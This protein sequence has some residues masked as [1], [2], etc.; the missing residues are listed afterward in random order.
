MS[1]M[2]RMEEMQPGADS[3]VVYEEGQSSE[4]VTNA[5]YPRAPLDNEDSSD[6]SLRL[7]LPLFSSK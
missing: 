5:S 7:G 1:R 2:S 4:S 3:E 6:T